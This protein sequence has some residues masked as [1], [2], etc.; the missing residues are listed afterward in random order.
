LAGGSA[1]GAADL[2]ADAKALKVTIS[3]HTVYG[4]HIHGDPNGI[5]YR[6]NKPNGTATGDKP[7]TEYAVLSGDYFNG[8][9]CFD[10]GNMETNT[11]DNGEGTMEAIYFGN[12]T[13]WGRGEGNGPWVMGDLENGLWAGNSSPY[14]G[15]TSLPVNLEVHHGRVEGRES[16]PAE[17][18]GHQ[19]R[20]CH[21]RHSDK[22]VRRTSPKLKIQSDEE[23]G[24]HRP[25]Y[26]WR[27]QQRRS[28]ELLRRCHDRHLFS[29]DAADDAVQA[30]IVAAGYG[31]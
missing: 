30:N 24:R 12:C 28:R 5:G 27:Q 9:C 25:R 20:Q 2:E 26:G 8:G 6:N 31:K 1:K 21:D 19:E 16:R 11:H 15:N 14:A 22:D 4:V 10:Y 17:P 18:L 29:S 23:G 3:G 13:F 7:E